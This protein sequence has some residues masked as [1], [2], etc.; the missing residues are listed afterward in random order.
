MKKSEA[1]TYL[2]KNLRKKDTCVTTNMEQCR[3]LVKLMLDSAET[4][5]IVVPPLVTLTSSDV[6][7]AKVREWEDEDETNNN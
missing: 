1:I 7:V 2:A 5:G 4:L 6:C 3:Y